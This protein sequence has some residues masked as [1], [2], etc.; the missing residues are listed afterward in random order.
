MAA[1]C[2]VGKKLEFMAAV[3]LVPPAVMEGKY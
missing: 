2:E 1:E 3:N